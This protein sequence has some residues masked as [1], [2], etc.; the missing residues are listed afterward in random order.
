MFEQNVKEK[1]VLNIGVNLIRI[2]ETFCLPNNSSNNFF[3]KDGDC[4]ELVLFEHCHA[5]IESFDF[6]IRFG[7]YY[8]NRLF[9]NTTT[10]PYLVNPKFIFDSNKKIWILMNAGY[11]CFAELEILHENNHKRYGALNDNNSY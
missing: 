10:D 4:V 2:S 11:V 8:G 1:S 5:S 7:K 3:L 9:F 6:P